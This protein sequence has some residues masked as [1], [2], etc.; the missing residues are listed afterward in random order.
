[1]RERERE[2]EKGREREGE[3]GGR[4]RTIESADPN[5]TTTP[6]NADLIHA[7]PLTW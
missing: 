7:S 3:R 1:M 2:R 5:A 6:P 4:E